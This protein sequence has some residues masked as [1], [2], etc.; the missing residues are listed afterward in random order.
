MLQLRV[1]FPC[2]LSCQ[3]PKSPQRMLA[4]HCLLLSPRDSA[5]NHMV[6]NSDPIP[7]TGK[8]DFML[9]SFVRSGGV[10]FRCSSHPCAYS[11]M[12]ICRIVSS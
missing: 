2:P 7:G 12:K 8:L 1:S 5:K 10:S 11:L 6:K 3:G 4:R 9:L